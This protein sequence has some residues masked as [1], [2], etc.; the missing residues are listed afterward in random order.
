MF[1]NL[2]N[3]KI[4]FSFFKNFFELLILI[5]DF[6]FCPSFFI[7]VGETKNKIKQNICDVFF[8]KD[9]VNN[10]CNKHAPSE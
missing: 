4:Q 5:L 1:Q 2:K 6:K 10:C 8:S 9:W 7:F 3:E